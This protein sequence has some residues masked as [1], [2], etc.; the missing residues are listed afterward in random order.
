MASQAR[1]EAV[2]AI[3]PH[4]F[5]PEPKTSKGSFL[6]GLSPYITDAESKKSANMLISALD[7]SKKAFTS[8]LSST[9]VSEEGFTSALQ[10]Y[11]GALLVMVN[12]STSNKNGAPASRPP[13]SSAPDEID[14][15]LAGAGATPAA[16]GIHA[17][18][19]PLSGDSPLRYA[20]KFSW[21]QVLLTNNTNKESTVEIADAVYELASALIAAAVWCQRRAALVHCESTP[22]GVP[23]GPSGQAYKLLRQAAG[24]YEYVSRTVLPLL[25]RTL[26]STSTTEATDCTAPVLQ[27]ATSC[28][29]ADAQSITVLR[30][31]AKGNSP[32]LIA[33]LAK[34]TSDYYKEGAA[35]LTSSSHKDTSSS[36]LMTYL[37]YKQAVFESYAQ[38]FNG[39]EQ[40]K[41]GQ[42]GIGLRCLK[43]AEAVFFNIK[44]LAAA[45]D[46][47]PPSSLGKVH[48]RFD[49][50]LD[51]VLYDT[52]RRIDKENSAVYYQRVPETA[53]PLPE[54]KRLAAATAFELPPVPKSV[55]ETDTS[56]VFKD[57]PASASENSTGKKSNKSNSS[58]GCFNC[59]FCCCAAKAVA[60]AVDEEVKKNDI[61]N[62]KTKKDE[63][64]G[65]KTEAGGSTNTTATAAAAKN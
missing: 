49:D 37:Q 31:I 6:E 4:C 65:K 45:F 2:P 3:H 59:L 15:A 62:G 24:M 11:I 27:A 38:I 41:A 21:N 48:S 26:T 25:S 1:E 35:A 10:E 36:K 29:I 8:A 20:V 52:L 61:A 56:A 14:T 23:S 53:P 28:A 22:L 43:E 44:K 17:A 30:A 7:D 64:G 58:G 19:G 40:W 55:K 32:A 18:L 51:R 33:S 54:G 47:A 13:P 46:K 50:E 16:G 42:A 57:L 12:A 39:V 5:S 34:D 60:G 63:E 9:A